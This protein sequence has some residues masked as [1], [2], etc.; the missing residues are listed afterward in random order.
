MVLTIAEIERISKEIRENYRVES[1]NQSIQKIKSNFYNEVKEALESLNEMAKVSLAEAKIE[2]YRKIM[3]KKE[4]MERNLKNFLLKRFEKLMRD[5][6]FEIGSKTYEPLTP[7]EKVFIMDTH[8]RMTK[9]LDNLSK[10]S[11]ETDSATSE[12]AEVENE[13]E[14]KKEVATENKTVKNKSSEEFENLAPVVVLSEYLPVAT[15]I[16]DFYLHKNDIAY[17]P[18]QIVD[19]LSSRKYARKITINIENKK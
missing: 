10:P 8:N 5:S 1:V 15:S 19:I 13:P 6:L 7:E 16:G 3:D 17:L 11:Q 4:S 18:I 12:K 14:E 9:Y 2:S